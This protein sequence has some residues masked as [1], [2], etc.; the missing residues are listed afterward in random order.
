MIQIKTSQGDIKIQLDEK[1][2][3]ETS[4]NF[5]KYV[6]EQFYNDTLFHRV[7]DG[8][9]VQGGG[10]T[11]DMSN[12]KTNDPIMNEAKNAKPNKRGTVAMARTADPHSA[13]SQ[14]FIN[15]SDNTFLNFS[16]EQAQ[17]YGYCAF[18]E[19]VDGMDVVDVI[20]KVKTGSRMGHSDVPVEDVVIMDV[21][22]I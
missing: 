18:A 6:R 1:N 21:V 17:T 2:T 4:A 15:L 11:K 14:F 7:I 12:K 9:M 3:P 8:F 16:G 13:S 19:V 5:L 10:L 22:E 20:A